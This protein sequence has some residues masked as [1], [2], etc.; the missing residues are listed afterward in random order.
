MERQER[1]G[2]L[3]CKMNFDIFFTDKEIEKSDSLPLEE[4]KKLLKKEFES[5]RSSDKKLL[6]VIDG[7]N[8]VGVFHFY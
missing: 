7:V 2:N 3:F 1:K 5:F 4:Q 8:E 6:I